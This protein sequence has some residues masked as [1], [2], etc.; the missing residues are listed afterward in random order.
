MT[1]T[2]RTIKDWGISDFKDFECLAQSLLRL[3]LLV[4]LFCAVPNPVC[5][6]A[7]DNT[8]HKQQHEE[9]ISQQ[10]RRLWKF[11]EE[12]QPPINS[13]FVQSEPSQ[14]IGSSRPT[15]ILPT[16][17]SKPGRY[18]GNVHHSSHHLKY[19]SLQRS[20]NGFTLGIVAAS[21]RY[22]YVIALRRILC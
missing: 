22:Y 15:R 4:L 12:P 3:W 5:V 14:R 17:G 6:K 19:T 7:Q 13:I 18:I 9:H 11:A 21:P 10:D 2:T 20:Y 16:H 1:E 8:I